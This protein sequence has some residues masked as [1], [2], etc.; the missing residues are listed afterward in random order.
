MNCKT[1]QV[2]LNEINKYKSSRAHM[3]K[4]CFTKY[5]VQK[6]VDKKIKLIE[7]H[8]SKCQSCGVKEHYTVYDFHHLDPS[9]KEIEL[10]CGKWG[11]EIL[12]KEA[13]KCALLCANCHRKVH[14]GII[15]L[16]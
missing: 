3:C 11:W 15:T 14:G 5:Q 6:G 2:E 12:T 4:K 9:Q 7:R 16:E 10:K 13:D 8:G 1:C